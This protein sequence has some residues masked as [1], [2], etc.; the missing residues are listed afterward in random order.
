MPAPTSVIAPALLGDETYAETYTFIADLTDGTY[1]QAQLIISN[2]GWGDGHGVC[3]LLIVDPQGESWTASDK[4]GVA[5]W[6]FQSVPTPELRVGRCRVAAGRHVAVDFHPGERGVS[7]TYDGELSSVLP[8]GGRVEVESGFYESNILLRA[9]PVTAQ[10]VA[11]KTVRSHVGWG[12]ADHSRS[13][14]KPWQVASQWVRFRGLGDEPLLALARL[15]P[16]KQEAVGWLWA[17]QQSSP[18]PAKVVWRLAKNPNGWVVDAGDWTIVAERPLFRYAPL[19]EYG[20]LA[21][22]LRTFVGRPVTFTLRATARR[23]P[24]PIALPGILEVSFANEPD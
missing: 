6:R 1:V 2:A 14:A 22:I 9:A 15:P 17:P 3:R 24:D 23:H 10:I 7:L 16:E 11:G 18:Q 20:A 12:Y 4:V 5:G 13:T 8:P 21:G 19:D